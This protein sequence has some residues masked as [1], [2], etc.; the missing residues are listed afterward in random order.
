M[1]K[2]LLITIFLAAVLGTVS[3]QNLILKTY[4][5]KTVSGPKVGTA[6]GFENS[7]QLEFGGFYQE[8]SIMQ[9][10]LMSEEQIAKLPR[11]YEREFYGAYFSVHV[12]KRDKFTTKVNVRT[13]VANQINFVITP[14]V[15]ASYKPVKNLR[16]GA[17]IG[18]R[19]LS[20]TLQGSVSLSL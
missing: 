6:I 11:N 14:S 17:G 9:S 2:Q 4:V 1:K 19:L 5:E 15:L 16:I 7:Y 8:A 12:F 10:M 18:S 3:A 20:P 13:G